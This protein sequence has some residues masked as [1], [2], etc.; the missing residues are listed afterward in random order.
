MDSH[1]KMPLKPSRVMSKLTWRYMRVS[2]Y[3]AKSAS[4]S[5][6]DSGGSTPMSGCH[7]TIEDQSA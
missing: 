5:C 6:G 4:Q 7:S 3:L 2:R 1:Q